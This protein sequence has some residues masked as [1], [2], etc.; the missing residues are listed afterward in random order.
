MDAAV[1]AALGW[2]AERRAL[3]AISCDAGA[4]RWLCLPRWDFGSGERAGRGFAWCSNGAP[5]VEGGGSLWFEACAT[6][7]ALALLRVL[8][9][10][11]RA[12]LHGGHICPV[13]SLQQLAVAP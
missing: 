9:H 6:T 8:L 12:L 11:Y 2:S 3:P 7:E 4:T 1:M 10:A 5:L 13:Q